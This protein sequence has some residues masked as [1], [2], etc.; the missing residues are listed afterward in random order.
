V[1]RSLSR[2][3]WGLSL[4][5]GCSSEPRVLNIEV[6]TG[7]ETDAMTQDPAVANVVV[8][9]RYDYEDV[10]IEA[11]APPGGDLDFG[12]VDGSLPYNF[13]VTGY[14]AAGNEVMRGTSVGGI[15]LESID[16]DTFQIFAQRLGA[17]ARPPGQLARTHTRAPAVNVGERYLLITGGDA[18][19]DAPEVEEY[20]LFAWAGVKA[21]AFPFAARTLIRMS[22]DNGDFL[23]GLGRDDANEVASFE[24]GEPNTNISLPEGLTSF[25][26]LAGG[27]VIVSRD[28]TRAFVVGATRPGSPTDAVLELTSDGTLIVRRLVHP[29]A[30]AAAAWFETVGL[31]VLGGSADGP[32]VEVLGEN[33]TTFAVRD[34]PPDPTA[35]AAAIAPSDYSNLFLFGGTAGAAG[36]ATR[37]VDPRCTSDC[38]PEAQDPM[39]FDVALTRVSAYPLGQSRFLAAGD[40]PDPSGLTRTFVVDYSAGI[41]T[42]LPL[43]EPRRGATLVDTPNGK[44]AVLGG[45]HPD[46]TPALTV[47]MF[48]P[49]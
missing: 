25:G 37:V 24:N 26:E 38:A 11:E 30:G 20:D 17:W 14:D 48:V 41:V 28:E 44:L 35:G 1:N 31:V 29:R 9:G 13:E 27:S 47:E 16:G 10:T 18:P 21:G 39:T 42:E 32:G 40:E 8:T 36:A 15:V 5:V 12:D 4:L 45:V 34:F 2:P 43:R 23:I 3:F 19:Q 49:E 7:H 6:V 33:A 46:G 22:D